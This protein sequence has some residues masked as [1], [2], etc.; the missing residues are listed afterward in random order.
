MTAFMQ[1]KSCVTVD[2]A[3]GSWINHQVHPI[4]HS[5]TV[6]FLH[7]AQ[8]QPSRTVTPFFTSV[9]FSHVFALFPNQPTLLITRADTPNPDIP[10][11]QLSLSQRNWTFF[12]F[13]LIVRAS[14][15]VKPQSK[16]ISKLLFPSPWHLHK[17]YRVHH[18]FY[19]RCQ[20]TKSVAG[21]S[22]SSA[23]L[24]F[25]AIQYQQLFSWLE[26]PFLIFLRGSRRALVNV[27]YTS[28]CVLVFKLLKLQRDRKTKQKMKNRVHS[29]MN[30]R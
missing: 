30:E 7:S 13:L 5:S 14:S 21:Q 29:L 4:S 17:H 11:H 3:Q 10:G 18:V 16:S 1:K 23:L 8:H 28:S 15:S 24:A 25:G 27:I 19:F 9:G 6:H 26:G 20:E 22:S 2:G 12:L